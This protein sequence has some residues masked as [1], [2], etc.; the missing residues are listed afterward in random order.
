MCHDALSNIAPNHPTNVMIALSLLHN[1]HHKGQLSTIK[2]FSTFEHYKN[3]TKIE[4]MGDTLSSLTLSLRV[5][6][7]S[8][9][10]TWASEGVS[11]QPVEASLC[12]KVENPDFDT[13][14]ESFTA[15]SKG[16]IHPQL[17]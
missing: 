10:L 2:P 1:H 4:Q 14:M 9:S 8:Q 11:G 7:H 16:G 13:G 3:L 12:K 17:T 5:S 15:T 6:I